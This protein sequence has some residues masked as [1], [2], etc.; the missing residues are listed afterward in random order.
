MGGKNFALDRS[1][2]DLEPLTVANTFYSHGV[3][4]LKKCLKI[5]LRMKF[6]LL[7]QICNLFLQIV[8]LQKF[9]FSSSHHL[10]GLGSFPRE[11]QHRSVGRWL[12]PTGEWLN[13]AVD[14]Y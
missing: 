1:E 8:Y 5:I 6:L 2:P 9:S 3:S 10:D 7:L 13:P 14:F 12:L 11:L 4:V